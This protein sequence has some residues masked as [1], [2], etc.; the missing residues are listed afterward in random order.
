CSLSANT[1]LPALS[2][3][4]GWTGGLPIGLELL[5]RSLDDARLIALGYAYEQATNHR[6]TPLSTPPLLSGRGPKP[7]TFTV[8]T[9]TASAPRSTVRPRA[10]VQFTYNSL[11]GT[12]AYNIR[13]SGVRADDVFAVVLSTNDEEGRPYI[14]RRLAGP[15]VSPAQG[16]LTLD[17]DERE[18]LESGEFYL[19]LMTR[20]HPFGT[21][22]KQV[23]PV[24]R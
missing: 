12:L 13:V 3:P 17:T 8:R 22:R 20:N 6:R 21:G 9:T 23:L 16:M 18:Q 14:E 7:I 24:R 4:A 15:S 1:G 5:G 10:R 11:T 2:I 19:E